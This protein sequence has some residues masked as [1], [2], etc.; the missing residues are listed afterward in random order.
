MYS[1]ISDFIPEYGVIIPYLPDFAVLSES[2]I[3][4][5][6]RRSAV[7]DGILLN[8]LPY[9]AGSCITPCT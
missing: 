4:M 7:T 6:E 5:N 9:A 8:K 3:G 2:Q 1:R